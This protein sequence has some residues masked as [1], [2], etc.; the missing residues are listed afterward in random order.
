LKYELLAIDMD[1]TLLN[2]SKLIGEKNITNIKKVI[3][4]GIKFVIASGRVP[5]ALK[6]YEYT[7]SRNQ[8]VICCNGAIILDH[9]KNI[10]SEKLLNKDSVLKIVDVLR[11]EKDTYYHFYVGNILYCEQ[12]QSAAKRFYEF[13]RGVEKKYRM[14]IRIIADTKEYVQS[15]GNS[16]D[17][18]VVMDSDNNYLRNLRKKIECIEGIEVT[19]S[20]VCNFE[21]NCKG[22]NKGE[23]LGSLASYYDIPIEKCI[24]VGN[25]ENDISMI[26]KAGLGIAVSNASNK[27][28]SEANYITIMDNNNDAIAEVIDKFIL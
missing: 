25:D 8:P 1:G 12:F 27:I 14:E 7:I 26:K 23:A 22:V 3:D 10:I 28:K 17:K 11:Q 19:S 4:K 20:G 24:A 21:I 16:V 9:N 18:I 13:N 2:D 6:Y 15:S 5:A